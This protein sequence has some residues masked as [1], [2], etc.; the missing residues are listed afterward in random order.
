MANNVIRTYELAFKSLQEERKA[1][2]ALIATQEALIVK[3][4][5][6]INRLMDIVEQQRLFQQTINL[7][8]AQERRWFYQHPDSSKPSNRWRHL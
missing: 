5:G 3:Y 4:E 6:Q 8:N 7:Q 2:D 1:K